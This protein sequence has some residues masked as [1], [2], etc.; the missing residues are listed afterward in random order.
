MSKAKEK[1]GKNVARNVNK[2]FYDSEKPSSSHI[3]KLNYRHHSRE[4]C[5]QEQ[6]TAADSEAE[7]DR[8]SGHRSSSSAQWRQYWQP[9]TAMSYRSAQPHSILM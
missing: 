6:T 7:F 4:W 8:G 2:F 5:T 1:L 9:V 3:L